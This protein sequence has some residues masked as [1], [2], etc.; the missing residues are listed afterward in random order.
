MTTLPPAKQPRDWPPEDWPP[1][2]LHRTKCFK[3]SAEAHAHVDAAYAHLDDSK[4]GRKVLGRF[5]DSLT[6]QQSVAD[7]DRYYARHYPN[8]N[9]NDLRDALNRN[10]P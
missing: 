5:L 6:K 10:A 4:E 8:L 1:C 2:P 7:R 3:L 9:W